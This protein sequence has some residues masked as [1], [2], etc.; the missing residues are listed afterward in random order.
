MNFAVVAAAG[1]TLVLWA[2]AFPMIRHALANGYGPLELTLG[3]FIAASATLLLISAGRGSLSLPR[4][5]WAPVAIV[6]VV[7]VT[8][9]HTFLNL[10]AQHVDAGTIAMIIATSPVFTAALAVAFLHERL[11][12]SGWF[13]IGIS[14]VGA[15]LIA[16]GKEGQRGIDPGAAF[17]LLAAFFSA[18]WAVMQ[19]PVAQRIGAMRATTYATCFGTLLLLP[20]AGSLATS[21]RTA[22]LHATL[23]VIYLGIFPAALANTMWA[24]SLSRVPASRLAVCMY[25]MPPI[26]ILITWLVQDEVPPIMAL[27]GGAVAILGVVVVNGSKGSTAVKV[28]QRA[29]PSPAANAGD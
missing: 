27:V 20:W 29:V 17:V 7:G 13:G 14:C 11:R 9:Y 18:I 5:E 4:R 21:M 25:L 8:L 16:V 23:A 24:F 10:G 12:A 1:S 15:M 2:S 19:R 22:P 6:G 3:R 26:T 28:A